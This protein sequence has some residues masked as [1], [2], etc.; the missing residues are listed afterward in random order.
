MATL[1]LQIESASLMEQLKNVLSLM[2]GVKIMSKDTSSK[3]IL[4]DD[5]PN[6]I[7]LSAMKEAENGQDAGVVRTDSLESFMNSMED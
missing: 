1:T 4:L 2:K 3:S 5:V 7:T 6:A